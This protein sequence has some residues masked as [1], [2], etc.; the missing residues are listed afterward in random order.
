MVKLGDASANFELLNQLLRTHYIYFYTMP[1]LVVDVVP[2][3]GPSRPPSQ[4]VCEV[5]RHLAL[6][7]YGVFL[8]RFIAHFYGTRFSFSILFVKVT[9]VGKRHS[10]AYGG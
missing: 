6:K 9:V 3:R 10:Y 4:T 1:H 5:V 2:G 8:A 7:P